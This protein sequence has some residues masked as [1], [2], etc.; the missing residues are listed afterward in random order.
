M[1]TASAQKAVSA[2]VQPPRWIMA[3]ASGEAS[4]SPSD[5]A[6][7]TAPMATLRWA[8]VTARAVTFMAR[9]EAVQDKARPTHTPMP[10][11]IIQ[12]DV[13]C[14]VMIRPAR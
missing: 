13:A 3:W 8:G 10:R 1:T 5:P 12:A 14:E 9:F 2:S 4:T 11:V 6:A 7:D